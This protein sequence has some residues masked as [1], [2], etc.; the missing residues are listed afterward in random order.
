MVTGSHN[1]D[2]QLSTRWFSDD[3]AKWSKQR[4]A[5]NSK[6]QLGT[7]EDD[8]SHNMGYWNSAAERLGKHEAT[9]EKK[10]R[11]IRKELLEAEEELNAVRRELRHAEKMKWSIN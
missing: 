1:P 8:K 4:M 10:C 3:D 9:L 6:T 7:K 5:K 2:A 11:V